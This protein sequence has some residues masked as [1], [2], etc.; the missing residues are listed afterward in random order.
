MQPYFHAKP[1]DQP[2]HAL[3][4]A[5]WLQLVQSVSLLCTCIPTLKRAL[6]DLQTGMMGGAVPN[7]FEVSVSGGHPNPE[8]LGSKSRSGIGRRLG[9]TIPSISLETLSTEFRGSTPRVERALSQKRLRED[10]IF[11]SIDWDVRYEKTGPRAF[12]MIQDQESVQY[13]DLSIHHQ[14]GP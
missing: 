6:A 7:F 10:V 9:S 14:L 3:M 5:I 1:L 11:H 13:D 8:E 4:P 12:P 2:W